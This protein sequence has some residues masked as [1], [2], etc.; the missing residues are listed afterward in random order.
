MNRI[1]DGYRFGYENRFIGSRTVTPEPEE[2]PE[3]F[4]T[5]ALLGFTAEEARRQIAVHESAHFVA[6]AVIGHTPLNLWVE[7]A[8]LMTDEGGH[9]GWG[10][11]GAN[12]IETGQLHTA[13]YLACLAIGERA[14]FRH[15][16]E[17][18][19]DSQVRRW[20]TEMNNAYGG[21]SDREVA[22][23]VARRV[24]GVGLVYDR[25]NRS[26]ASWFKVQDNAD[27]IL[28]D[29]WDAVNDLAEALL[30]HGRLDREAALRV[31]GAL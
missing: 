21:S 18:G 8:V 19:T 12:T 17:A 3:H 15:M 29:H 22:D 13:D 6:F 27:R 11:S 24:N 26:E 10:T 9:Q 28:D 31:T 5:G 30:I 16:A 2:L 14:E 7:E 20:C 4:S 1:T 23:S 25:R